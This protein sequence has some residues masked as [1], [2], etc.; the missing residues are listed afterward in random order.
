MLEASAVLPVAKKGSAVSSNELFASVFAEEVAEMLESMVDLAL[1]YP[2][3]RL[4][5]RLSSG[6]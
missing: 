3:S 5:L 6:L 2:Y 4:L 1:A